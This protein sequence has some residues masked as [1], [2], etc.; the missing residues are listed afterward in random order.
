MLC[1][2]DVVA[3]MSTTTTVASS[4]SSSQS[5]A[6]R[7]ELLMDEIAYYVYPVIRLLVAFGVVWFCSTFSKCVKI[8]T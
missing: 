6:S 5:A 4:S 1:L 2:W 8:L 3:A 7:S